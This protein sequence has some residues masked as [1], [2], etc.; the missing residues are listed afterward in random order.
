MYSFSMILVFTILLSDRQGLLRAS[1]LPT[2]PSTLLPS[3]EGSF[4]VNGV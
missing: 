1:V 4:H 3:L 2:K